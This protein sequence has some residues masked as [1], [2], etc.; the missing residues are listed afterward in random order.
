MKKAIIAVMLFLCATVGANAASI[1]GNGNISDQLINFSGDNVMSGNLTMTTGKTLTIPSGGTL[2]MSSGSTLTSTGIN[3]SAKGLSA[4]Y[5]VSAATGAFTGAVNIAGQT[6]IGAAATPSTFTA[7]GNL[8]IPGSFTQTVS[9]RPSTDAY[10]YVHKL[11]GDFFTGGAA[12]KTYGYAIDATR[13]SGSAASGDSNDALYRGSFSNYAAND[14]NFIMRGINMSVNNRSGGTLGFLDNALGNQN[15]TGGTVGTITGLTVTPENYGTVSD[16]FGGVDVVMKNEGAV[17]TSEF[18]V[19]VRNLNN[20]LGTA[21][22][23]AFLVSDTGANIGFTNGLN[24]NGATVTNDLKLHSGD[25]I[26][27]AAAG[28]VGFSGSIDV[29]GGINAGS[30]NVGIIDATGK[31]PALSSTYLA[32]LSGTNLTGIALLDSANTFTADMNAKSI[33]LTGGVSASTVSIGSLSSAE[34]ITLTDN[35]IPMQVNVEAQTNPGSAY[36]LGGIYGKASSKSGTD[37]ANVQIVGVLARAGMNSNVT[38]AYGTQSHLSIASGARSTGNMTAVSGKTILADSVNTGIV[39]AGLFTLEGPTGAAVSPTT[40]YGIWA[41]IVDTNIHSGVM[42]H[43]NGSTVG[44]GLTMAKTGTGAFTKDVTLQNGETIDNA[45]DTL[46]KVSGGFV[47]PSK[48]KAELLVYDPVV[49]GEQWICSDCSTTTIAFSTGTAIG[50]VSDI[51]G[52]T[53]AIN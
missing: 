11:T 10:V 13:P 19:R 14:T 18:G 2:T 39:T 33:D 20:S 6:T 44:S 42:V 30:G 45:T 40:A 25:V 38:D 26:S 34:A 3:I 24:L 16:L 49:Y 5:G 43:A 48:S 22:D 35:Y 28:T 21:V 37:M 4:T 23:S 15:K 31:I 52:K 46:I 17:A 7:T 12:Q 32:N 36:T 41:D 47:L 50:Q 9:T 53:T 27:N 1:A 8:S 29:V 51:I